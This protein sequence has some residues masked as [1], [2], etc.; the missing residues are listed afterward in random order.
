MK[1]IRQDNSIRQI[2]YDHMVSQE[3]WRR[4]RSPE[5]NTREMMEIFLKRF[6]DAEVPLAAM[7]CKNWSLE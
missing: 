1:G 6:N 7:A 2:V 4:F 3:N 5:D